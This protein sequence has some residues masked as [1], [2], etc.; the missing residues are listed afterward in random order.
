MSKA[1]YA[2]AVKNTSAQEVKAPLP[3]KAPKGGRVKQGTDLR[4]GK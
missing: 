2:G 3:Q 4:T 1:T